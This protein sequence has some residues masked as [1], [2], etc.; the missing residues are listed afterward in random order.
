M[1]IYKYNSKKVSK[2]SWL[3]T[4]K[5]YPGFKRKLKIINEKGKYRVWEKEAA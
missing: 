5:Q 4:L 3:K 2:T 1:K